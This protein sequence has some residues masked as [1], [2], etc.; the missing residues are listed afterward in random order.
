MAAV[1]SFSCPHCKSALRAKLK[2]VGKIVRCPKCSKEVKVPSPVDDK[3]DARFGRAAGERPIERGRDVSPH[4]AGA[5]STDWA[6]VKGFALQI[7]RGN[8]DQR[9]QAAEILGQC[10]DPRAIEALIGALKD[11]ERTVRRAAAASLKRLQWGTTPQDRVA[12]AIAAETIEDA[13]ALG[14]EAVEPLIAAVS[15]ADP[16]VRPAILGALGTLGDQRAYEPITKCLEDPELRAAAV[17]ALS[18][19]GDA[20]ALPAVLEALTD[21][22]AEVRAQAAAA[23]GKLGD[24]RAA[25]ALAALLSD[26]HGSVRAAAATALGRLGDRQVAG[27]LVELLEKPHG[28]IQAADAIEQLGDTAAARYVA[29][30]RSRVAELISRA[31]ELRYAITDR[32]R[33]KEAVAELQDLLEQHRDVLPSEDLL[34]LV[35]LETVEARVKVRISSEKGPQERVEKQVV[36]CLAVNELARQ[37]LA[38]RRILFDGWG[39]GELRRG[40]AFYV[41]RQYDDA[42]AEYNIVLKKNPTLATAWNNR[43]CAC[44]AQGNHAAAL[45]DFTAALRVDPACAAAYANRATIFHMRGDFAQ[46]VENYSKSIH[47]ARTPVTLACRG[48]AYLDDGKFAQAVEDYTAALNLDLRI[49]VHN[50]R[51]IALFALGRY[52]DAVEDFDKCCSDGP[53]ET[54]LF[55]RALANHFLGEY[56]SAARDYTAL[57]DH[58]TVPEAFNNRGAARLAF[59]EVEGAISDLREHLQR[60]RN[61]T[62]LFNLAVALTLTAEFDAA[63]THCADIIRRRPEYAPAHNLSGLLAAARGDAATA[64]EHFNEAIRLNPKY[65]TAISN[66]GL[67][68]RRSGE[69]GKAITD[70]SEALRLEPENAAIWFNRAVAF[71]L[72]GRTQDAQSDQRTAMELDPSLSRLVG[73]ASVE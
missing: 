6:D 72:L 26:G 58:A 21:E 25:A 45:A 4:E 47:F 10:A 27:R 3:K 62:T 44:L 46:A 66:R 67:L 55:N 37:E 50:D 65:A 19:L 38:A 69:L 23:T 57:L 29:E 73:S 59:G 32:D 70:Y 48:D 68:Y 63:Q 16:L 60:D 41:G 53:R 39:E 30:F 36:R 49:D 54:A 12:L 28:R 42:I 40:N 71:A 22:N 15:Q 18:N 61:A 1:F 11:R 31:R 7:V 9:A 13:V 35:H 17:E 34:P 33:A 56:E 20:R 8:P 14:A 2:G 51:G 5:A 24:K 43:G 64:A 52:R